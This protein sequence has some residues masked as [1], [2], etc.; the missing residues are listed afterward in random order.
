MKA[1]VL[2]RINALLALFL[3]ALGF[4]GCSLFMVK[5]GPDPGPIVCEYGCPYAQFEATGVVTDD[6][7]QPLENMQVLV[8]TK[9]DSDMSREYMPQVYTDEAGEYTLSTERL[10]P[11]DSMDIIVTD[12]AGVY[13]SDSVRVKVD[14]DRSGVS[15]DDH[16]NEGVGKVYQDFQLKKK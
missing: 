9:W 7:Q 11:T 5:Y 12:T 15:P 16:W 2:T 4:N 8:H 14:Y 1:K 13:E 10:F 6:E 3:S